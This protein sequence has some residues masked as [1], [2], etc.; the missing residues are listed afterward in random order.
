MAAIDSRYAR[1]LAAVVAEQKLDAAKVQTQLNDFSETL[2]G[3]AELREVLENPSI[4]ETQKLKVIDA[5]AA[6]LG[7]SGAVRN[8]IAVIT[9][10]ERLNELQTILTAYAALADEESGVADAEIVSAQPL[11]EAS[12]RLLE[13]RVSKLTGGQR[14]RATYSEDASLLGG[15]VIRIGST[16]YD[17]SIRA[18]LNQLRQTMVS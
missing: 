12:K 15:A 6:K 10:H 13:D 16:V 3:S 14:V 1:A 4:A 5:I 7:M 8:F 9:H 11:N 18:Q 2:S 17:G